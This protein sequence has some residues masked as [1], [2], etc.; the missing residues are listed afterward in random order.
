M[1]IERFKLPEKDKQ[2]LID[3]EQDINELRAE[4]K[5]AKEVGIDTTELEKEVEA[6]DKS[7]KG[8]LKHYS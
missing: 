8:L 1:T 2:E 5:I 3:V 4:F 7:R 6:A